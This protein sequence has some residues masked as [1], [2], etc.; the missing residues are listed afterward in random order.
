MSDS[1]DSRSSASALDHAIAADRS[2]SHG[3][4]GV[5]GSTT[6]EV[7]LAA[8]ETP[9]R[10]KC[11][12]TRYPKMRHHVGPA[13][14]CRDRI[15]RGITTLSS[16]SPPAV[17]RKRSPRAPRFICR[18]RRGRLRRALRIS[19]PFRVGAPPAMCPDGGGQDVVSSPRPS[20]SGRG[21]P[22][23][24]EP[25]ALL[26]SRQVFL[27][28]GGER[29]G[30]R[31]YYGGA[32]ARVRQSP[33]YGAALSTA[34]TPSLRA[35]PTPLPCVEVPTTSNGGTLKL[36][37]GS[38]S[39]V[40]GYSQT[41]IGRPLAR[42]ASGEPRLLTTLMRQRRLH[43]VD[44]SSPFVRFSGRWRSSCSLP[45]GGLERAARLP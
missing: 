32:T 29:P 31:R 7:T 45:V 8:A 27:L 18:R 11:A 44:L 3:A 22:Q 43:L 16:R 12:C 37:S 40:L 28:V 9:G 10:M 35:G 41:M 36:A 19:S 23:R 30:I 17:T 5:R 25:D 14:R 38:R 2:D 20:L 13:W 39:V 26:D 34:S 24:N 21:F 6:R 42:A 33:P 1:C 4:R 15:L